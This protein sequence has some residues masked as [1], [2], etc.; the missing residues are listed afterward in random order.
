MKAECVIAEN[1]YL[2]VGQEVGW[3]G[4]G[5][6]VVILGTIAWRLWYQKTELLAVL[7]LASL[8]GISLVNFLN[9][10]WTDDTLSLLWWGAAV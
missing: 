7:L 1:Y 2:Q 10:A 8:A 5:L 3:L 4:L 9:H 6:F